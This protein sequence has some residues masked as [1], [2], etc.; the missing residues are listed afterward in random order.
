MM[1]LPTFLPMLAAALADPEG[2]LT[3][4][5]TYHVAGSVFPAV[6]LIAAGSVD[7]LNGAAL[8]W[9]RWMEESY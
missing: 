6:D 1:H 3:A 4:V 7:T 5:L 9:K 8:E 2:L